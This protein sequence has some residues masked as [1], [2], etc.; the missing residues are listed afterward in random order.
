MI[1]NNIGAIPFKRIEL[2]SEYYLRGGGDKWD[3]NEP[4]NYMYD[5][6]ELITKDIDDDGQFDPGRFDFRLAARKCRKGRRRN[7]LAQ[8]IQCPPRER[9]SI[10]C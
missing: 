10:N 4:R 1:N 2:G 6:G 9:L 3:D 8:K 7:S 5:I